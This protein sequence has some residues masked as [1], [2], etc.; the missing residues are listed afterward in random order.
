[1]TIQSTD[2]QEIV[3]HLYEEQASIAKRRIVTGRVQVSRVT[4]EH[5]QWLDENLAREQVEIERTPI[6]RPVQVPP[7]VREEGDTIVIPILEEILVVERRLI[8]KEE[9]RLRRVRSNENHRER[10][11]LRRQEALITRAPV[12]SSVALAH[13]TD[14]TV[15][16]TKHSQT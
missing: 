7:S 12:E 8:L 6:G 1:M 14:E 2:P 9:I 11:M 3:V 16:P 4:S 10:V 5:E 15:K 13:A